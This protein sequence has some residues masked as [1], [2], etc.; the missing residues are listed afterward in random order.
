MLSFPA[1]PMLTFRTIGAVCHLA[2]EEPGDLRDVV[3]SILARHL[4]VLV[5][6]HLIYVDA[7]TV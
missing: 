4:L 2:D 3:L 5:L 6:R 1:P 7:Q